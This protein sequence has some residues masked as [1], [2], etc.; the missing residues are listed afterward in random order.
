M[1]CKSRDTGYEA[2]DSGFGTQVSNFGL[3]LSKIV[4]PGVQ[5]AEGYRLTA[6]N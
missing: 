5:V 3:R 6:E 1:E 2:R 4:E